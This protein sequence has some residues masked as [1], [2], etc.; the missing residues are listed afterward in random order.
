MQSEESLLASRQQM[1]AS[2][3]EARGIVDARVLE[4]FGKVP[5]HRFVLPWKQDDAYC[6]RPLPIGQE[7]TISQPYIVGCMTQALQIDPL[8]R[9]LEIGTGSGYQ[10]AILAEL[11]AE[12]HTIE[13]IEPLARNARQVLDELGYDNIRFKLGDGSVGWPEAGPFDGIIVTAAAPRVSETLLQQLL[14]HGTLVVPAGGRQRQ[15]LYAVTRE[16]GRLVERR[17]C[18]CLFVELLGEEGWEK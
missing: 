9:V 10:T 17:L 11:A 3:L 16:S 14:A 2:Q 13:R 8:H 18:D 4:A 1:V 6:D 5:R 12:V 15:T 7:Q